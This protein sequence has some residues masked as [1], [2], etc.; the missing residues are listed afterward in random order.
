MAEA[1]QSSIVG[2]VTALALLTLLCGGGGAAFGY[3]VF[4]PALESSEKAS[5][6]IVAEPARGKHAKAHPKP[7]AKGDAPAAGCTPPQG[8]GRQKVVALPPIVTNLKAPASRWI[9]LEAALVIKGEETEFGDVLRHE[10]AQDLMGRLRQLKLSEIEGA[11][12]M[13]QL[14]SDLGELIRIRTGDKVADLI[15]NGLIVE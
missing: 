10:V 14:R 3:L 1:K 11:E 8:V 6:E 4:S 12:G 2:A 9:R 13:L 15:V 7:H 5:T